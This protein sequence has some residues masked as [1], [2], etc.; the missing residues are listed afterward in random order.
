MIIILTHN[1]RILSDDEYF[2]DI[3][4]VGNIKL[5]DHFN[6]TQS[7]FKI[8]GL[9][10]NNNALRQRLCDNQNVFI[11]NELYNIFKYAEKMI[12]YNFKP[13]RL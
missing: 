10:N 13:C 2:I 6:N 7:F 1:H 11:S 5:S 4:F 3:D 8:F 9:P 12:I